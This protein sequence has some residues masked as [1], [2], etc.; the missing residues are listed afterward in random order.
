MHERCEGA[1]GIPEFMPP[2]RR[3]TFKVKNAVCIGGSLYRQHFCDVKSVLFFIF[4]AND[5]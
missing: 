2:V 4:L 1:L 5:Y 3:R